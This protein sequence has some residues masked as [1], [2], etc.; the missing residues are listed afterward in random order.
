MGVGGAQR[1]QSAIRAVIRVRT[2]CLLRQAANWASYLNG[3]VLRGDVHRIPVSPLQLAVHARVR[4]HV[5][6]AQMIQFATQVF[7]PIFG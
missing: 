3:I 1:I 7:G 4:A 2:R 5:D 6:G